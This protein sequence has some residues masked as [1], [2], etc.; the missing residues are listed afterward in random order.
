MGPTGG[1]VFHGELTLDQWWAARPLLGW[2]VPHDPIGGLYLCQG[3][4]APGRR[5]HG[6]PRASSPPRGRAGRFRGRRLSSRPAGLYFLPGARSN[7]DMTPRAFPFVELPRGPPERPSRSPSPDCCSAPRDADGRGDK[8]DPRPPERPDRAP[9]AE[10]ARLRRPARRRRTRPAHGARRLHRRTAPP[11]ADCRCRDGAAAGAGFE[12]LHDEHAG[13][14]G[15][16]LRSRRCRPSARHSRR[17]RNRTRR[18]GRTDDGPVER[19]ERTPPCAARRR[20]AD[21]AAEGADGRL[22]ELT[23]QKLL[24]AVLS[25]AAARRGAGRLLVQPFQ[26]LH[27]QGPAGADVPHRVRARRHPP[28]RARVRSAICSA[29]S[30]TARRCSSIWTTGRARPPNTRPDVNPQMQQMQQRLSNARLRAGPSAQRLSSGRAGA[31]RSAGQ[32]A[33]RG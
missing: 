1:H 26:R 4:H 33:Q 18:T 28:A 11:R 21:A 24:R 6:R 13:T 20:S 25:D 15:R 12:T 17:R 32:G 9:R 27:R 30:P 3:R 2:A 23:Q 31:A 19:H 10:P 8:R 14:G 16:V 7:R 5:H 29:P 22:N